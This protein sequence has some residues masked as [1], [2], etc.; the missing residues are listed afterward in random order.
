[1]K[2]NQNIRP[3]IPHVVTPGAAPHGRERSSG[4][5]VS[6]EGREMAIQE[7]KKIGQRDRVSEVRDNLN[8]AAWKLQGVAGL[9]FVQGAEECVDLNCDQANGLSML[10]EQIAEEIKENA[11]IIAD[12]KP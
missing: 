1:M 4:F 7:E 2:T 8:R 6:K 11:E 10:L 5:I 3:K 12:V 9:V